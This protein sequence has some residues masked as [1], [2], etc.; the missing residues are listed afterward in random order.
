MTKSQLRQL[1]DLK[2]EIE[3]AKLELELQSIR[4]RLVTP[5]PQKLDVPSFV[6]KQSVASPVS[7]NEELIEVQ[8]R[9]A[10]YDKVIQ[11]LTE[12]MNGSSKNIAELQYKKRKSKSKEEKD[13]LQGLIDEG[14]KANQ[15]LQAQL[16][17]AKAGRKQAYSR[18]EGVRQF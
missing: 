14:I 17:I 5:P 6:K 8:K 10:E 12:E 13:Q 4:S 2:F 11:S 1:E 15:D 18:I 16:S 3:K 7:T 9:I